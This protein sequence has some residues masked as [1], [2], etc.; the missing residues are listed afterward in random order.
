M[1]SLD[2]AI[3]DQHTR[4]TTPKEEPSPA[5]DAPAPPKEGASP[6]AKPARVVLV[7]PDAKLSPRPAK[8]KDVEVQAEQPGFL[9][10]LWAI[11]REATR[12]LLRERVKRAPFNPA[13]IAF[14]YNQADPID[15]EQAREMQLLFEA[16]GVRTWRKDYNPGDGSK[17][18]R[19]K[20]IDTGL[21][22]SIPRDP[23]LE[24]IAKLPGKQ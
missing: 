9:E 5:T 22:A 18:E 7:K 17:N 15:L 16:E 10:E 21:A 11:R 4:P 19:G 8:K 13:W 3:G 20:P 1:S 23:L 2:E 6:P 12:K 24:P 14:Q